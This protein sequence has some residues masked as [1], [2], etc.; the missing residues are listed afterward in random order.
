MLLGCVAIVM[1][2]AGDASIFGWKR[3]L[4]PSGGELFELADEVEP[5]AAHAQLGL[6]AFVGLNA[7][8]AADKDGHAGAPGVVCVVMSV[9]SFLS[10]AAGRSV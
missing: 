5:E 8:R 4:L 6:A 2:V 9:F 1:F 3:V 10:A 7:K